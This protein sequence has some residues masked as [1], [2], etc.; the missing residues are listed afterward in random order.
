MNKVWFKDPPPSVA[1]GAGETLDTIEL[2]V[3][4]EVTDAEVDSE[5]VGVG[6]VVL[7]PS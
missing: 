7:S 3:L 6:V 1:V 2:I 5:A 4:E